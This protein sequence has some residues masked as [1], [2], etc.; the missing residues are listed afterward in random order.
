MDIA[1][2]GAVMHGKGISE[3]SLLVTPLITGSHVA[4]F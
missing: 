3:G 2:V 1:V 4:T